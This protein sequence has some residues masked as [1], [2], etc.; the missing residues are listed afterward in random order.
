MK[1]TNDR[2]DFPAYQM[3]VSFSA[4]DRIQEPR[5]ETRSIFHRDAKNHLF[6]HIDYDLRG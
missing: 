1:R 3:R 6:G 2:P 5:K 4:L